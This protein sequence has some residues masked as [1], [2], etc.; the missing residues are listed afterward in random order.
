M[1]DNL[2]WDKFWEIF[3]RILLGN[4]EKLLILL[5]IMGIL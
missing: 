5:V 3:S 2:F 4:F 1:E